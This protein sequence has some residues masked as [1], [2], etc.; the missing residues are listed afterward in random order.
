MGSRQRIIVTVRWI[1]WLLSAFSFGVCIAYFL[2]NV[3]FYLWISSTFRAQ[4]GLAGFIH[5]Y[6][7]LAAIWVSVKPQGF[8]VW[9]LFD[10]LFGLLAAAAIGTS[11]PSIS[12]YCSKS[13]LTLY[14]SDTNFAYVPLDHRSSSDVSTLTN[15]FDSSYLT[16]ACGMNAGVAVANGLLML[17]YFAFPPL[18]RPNAPP[19]LTF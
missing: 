3:N 1:Q 19:T 14:W 9:A 2:T 4:V 16:K 10:I 12:E 11:E 7:Y 6:L 5:V 8:L 15:V 18:C 17:A 13:S